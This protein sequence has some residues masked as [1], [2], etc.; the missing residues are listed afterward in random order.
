MPPLISKKERGDPDAAVAATDDGSGVQR[1]EVEP[2]CGADP[3]CE[4]S[5]SGDKGE[6]PADSAMGTAGEELFSMRP[7][8]NDEAGVSGMAVADSGRRNARELTDAAVAV[9]V[10]GELAREEKAARLAAAIEPADCMRLV[11]L[12]PL[13][14][15][16][17]EACQGADGKAAPAYAP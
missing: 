5:C 16:A 7:P 1:P 15:A 8:L 4:V 9:K 12:M 13:L 17:D 3:A 2:E 10:A 14:L 11:A 6:P